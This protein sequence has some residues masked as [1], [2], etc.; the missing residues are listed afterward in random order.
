MSDIKLHPPILSHHEAVERAGQF[1]RRRATGTWSTGS[2]WWQLLSLANTRKD[3]APLI[4]RN[5]MTGIENR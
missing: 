1:D 4:V 5:E 2:I 3:D